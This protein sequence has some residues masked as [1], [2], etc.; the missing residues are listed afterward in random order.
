[1]IP[2]VVAEE[3][4]FGS[5]RPVVAQP[6]VHEAWHIFHC[7][8]AA[9]V[10]ERSFA[11][12]LGGQE[13]KQARVEEMIGASSIKSTRDWGQAAVR[14]CHCSQELADLLTMQKIWWWVKCKMGRST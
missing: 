1:M 13:A 14:L 4:V 6:A 2:I 11:H 10:E 5:I 7:H 8:F 3:H 9:L 12:L